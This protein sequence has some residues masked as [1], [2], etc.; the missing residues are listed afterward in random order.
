MLLSNANSS[1][2]IIIVE[3]QSDKKLISSLF[4]NLDNIQII[5]AGTQSLV[6]DSMSILSIDINLQTQLPPTKGIIDRDY[7]IPLGTAPNNKFTVMTDSRDIE[8]MMIESKVFEII[9]Q[10]YID[11][12]KSKKYNINN[13]NDLRNAAINI[14][15]QVGALRYWSQSTKTN[16]SFKSLDFS[17]ILKKNK[18]IE[19]NIPSLIKHIQG[20]QKG[21]TISELHFNAA[22][23]LHKNEKYFS[24]DYLICRGHDLIAV[25]SVF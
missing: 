24:H 14:C 12:L 6:V 23:T 10:E 11:I 8:C 15:R 4:N 5:A 2:A 16:I 25:I 17:K 13:S 21:K 18:I 3:G 1:K 22:Q 7:L 9:M 20:A 19:I